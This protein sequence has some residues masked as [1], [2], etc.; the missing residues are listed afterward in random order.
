[1]N[2]NAPDYPLMINI[3]LSDPLDE[4]ALV[5]FHRQCNIYHHWIRVFL[6]KVPKCIVFVTLAFTRLDH[7]MA[8]MYSVSMRILEDCTP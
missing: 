6:K 3:T 2:T 5:P 7:P 1:M 4:G 8:K